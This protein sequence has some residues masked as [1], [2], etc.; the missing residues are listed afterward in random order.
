MEQGMQKEQLL[1]NDIE[2]S[3]EIFRSYDIRGV[4]DIDPLNPDFNES[5]T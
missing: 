1:I 2:V 3:P 4:A 5:L